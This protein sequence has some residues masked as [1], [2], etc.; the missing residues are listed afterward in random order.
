MAEIIT[1]NTNPPK[2]PLPGD[3]SAL[4]SPDVV[5][6]LKASQQPQSFGDQL[7]A[8]AVAAAAMP[9]NSCRAASIHVRARCRGFCRKRAHVT[10]SLPSPLPLLFPSTPP[11]SYTPPPPFSP[12]KCFSPAISCALLQ[13]LSPVASLPSTPR[14]TPSLHRASPVPACSNWPRCAAAAASNPI[15][16][17]PCCHRSSRLSL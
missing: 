11:P 12:F 15:P 8:A 16:H 6:N 7:A 13:P 9:Q 2:Q 14:S 5:A 10:R 3:V 1:P 17:A 4:V